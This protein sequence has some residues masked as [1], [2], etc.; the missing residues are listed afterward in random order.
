M[1]TIDPRNSEHPTQAREAALALIEAKQAGDARRASCEFAR[2]RHHLDLHLE[3][4]RSE[5]RRLP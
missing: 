1:N 4:I 3:G 5:R 2:L